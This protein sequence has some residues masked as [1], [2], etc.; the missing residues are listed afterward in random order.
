MLKRYPFLRTNIALGLLT[1]ASA[2]ALDKQGSGHARHTDVAESGQRISGG[3]L[4]GISVFNP[5]YAA[6]PDNTGLALFRLAGHADIDLI[7]Q[8]LL[9]PLD[10]NMFTDRTQDGANILVPS[11]L[12]LI[13]GVASTWALG[14]GAMEFGVRGEID[15]G[16][17]RPTMSQGY[18]DARA[19]YSF[20]SDDFHSVH[21]TLGANHF[22]S[23]TTLGVFGY[24]PSYAARPDN[25]GL[26]LLRYAER[27][28][29]S[30][31]WFSAALD[32]TFFTD[33]NTNA[34]APSELDFTIDV[35]ATSGTIGMHLAYERDMPLDQGDLV[36]H[37][38]FVY[39]TSSFAHNLSSPP[40][41]KLA[42]ESAPAH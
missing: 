10:V 40:R 5:S 11:E 21:H 32:F 12:D 4:F 6:R 42:T 37:F 2:H 18:V 13:G 41:A 28:G 8:H 34:I 9:L 22:S 23:S 17:D 35:G 1:S 15:L 30:R 39:L 31:R 26:A 14:K 27:L 25:T 20:E 7:G 33:R 36:Q 38:L 29:Y 3:A 24:N 16:I 19:K